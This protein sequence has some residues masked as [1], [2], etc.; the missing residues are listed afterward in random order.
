MRVFPNFLRSLFVTSV[1]SFMA[2]IALVGGIVGGLF[3]LGYLPGLDLLAQTL[4]SQIKLFL[5]VFGDGYVLQG[6]FTISFTSAFV[7][8]NFHL[9]NYY[10]YRNLTVPE[11]R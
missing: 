4:G 10:W 9:F 7:G 3:L 8:A 6:I 1:L 5:I 11:R 2:P